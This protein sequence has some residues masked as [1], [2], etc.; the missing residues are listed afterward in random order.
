[1][2]GPR[3]ERLLASTALA[4]ILAAPIGASAQDAGAPT[5]PTTA[6]EAAA[7]AGAAALSTR[8]A[9]AASPAPPAE[10]AEPAPAPKDAVTPASAP[11]P[12]VASEQVAA[13]APDPLATL[14]PADRA[15][16][17]KIRD[18]LAAKTDKI[19]A[20]KRER[21]AAES[22]YQARHLAP[23]WLDK[24]VENARARAAIA[25]LKGADADGLD[26]SDYKAPT[27]AGLGPDALAEAELKL[28]DAVLTYAR[29][30]Q[31]GRFPYTRVSQNIELP[32]AP[33]D[34]AEVLAKVADAA[35]VG[36]ALDQFSPPYENYKK[37]K[38]ML[39]QMR[40]KATGAQEQEIADGPLLKLNAKA[41][42]EDP[43]VPLLRD[44]LG[45]GGGASDLKYDA[46]V[47]EAVKKFQRANELPVTGN[48]DSRTIRELNG[49]PR[50]RQIDTVISNMERWR[51]YPR[52]LGA[53]HVIV[54]LPDF[55]LRVMHAGAEVWSTRLVIGKPDMATPLLSETMKYITINPTWNV[56]PSIVRNEYLPALQQDP[57]VLERLGLR[58]VYNR[59]GSV[60]IFQPPGEANALGR[61]RFNFP[62]RFL[63]YQHDTP[64][65]HMFAYDVRAYSHGCM[66]VQDPAKYAEILLNIARPSENW[67]AERIKRMFGTGEQDIQ[68]PAPIWV[69]LTYQNAF[70]DDAGK[71]QIRR[72]IYNIDSRTLAAI[73]TERGAIEP[74]QERKREEEVVATNQRRSAAQPRTVSF[75]EALFG[76]GR[77]AQGRPV[78]PRRVTR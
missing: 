41:P 77:P 8:E 54:N 74:P 50:D 38:A 46:K 70:V 34:P 71:L 37:L 47:A 58:L 31:A 7:R 69:L 18:L 49:P 26:P 68:L 27:F 15:V 32:Q 53:A 56:P 52:D 62:N 25:R 57:T 55:S 29:H 39:A 4:L 17:E 3:Y 72:D 60:H 65:K 75:F 45:L 19:F 59:D 40:G 43:R 9:S 76:F 22:F 30:L 51:W 64:D 10:T 24:G 28:T 5:T 44:K 21:A 66:R 1:M 16:A 61:I 63:V 36:T 35:D 6:S 48:V 73:K 20:G 42:M 78:P 13:P 12:S 11:S 23:L 2:S 67:T 14:D 33:P